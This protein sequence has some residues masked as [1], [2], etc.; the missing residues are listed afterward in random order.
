MTKPETTT[1][2]RRPLVAG[3]S[4]PLT[5]D[6]DLEKKFIYGEKSQPAEAKAPEPKA[7]EQDA[8]KGQARNAANRVPLTTRIRADFGSALCTGR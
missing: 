1:K 4:E 5:N 7:P 8:S 2:E 3:L 6:P